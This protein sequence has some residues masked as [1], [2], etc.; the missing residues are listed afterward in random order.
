M[1]RIDTGISLPSILPVTASLSTPG[2][3]LH[4][5]CKP[6][7]F[8]A[9]PM[10]RQDGIQVYRRWITNDVEPTEVDPGFIIG[11]YTAPPMPVLP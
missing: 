7:R 6:D 1:L 11:V 2:R 9:L 5:T 4:L 3:S 8:E 10:Q